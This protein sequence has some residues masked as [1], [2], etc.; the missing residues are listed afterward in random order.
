MTADLGDSEW[1]REGLRAA[2]ERGQEIAEQVSPI[3][4][5]HGSW[6]FEALPGTGGGSFSSAVYRMHY[7]LIAVATPNPLSVIVKIVRR[8]DQDPS[9]LHYWRRESEAYCSAD[10]RERLPEGLALPACYFWADLE[11]ASVIVLEDVGSDDRSARTMAWYGRFAQ[12]LGRMNGSPHD[13]RTQPVWFSND[14]VGSQA[15]AAS[16]SVLAL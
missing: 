11:L 9:G 1:V 8:Q 13:S 4:G 14:F 2:G 10:L 7:S 3:V 15:R 16:I 12:Q 6:R 5:Q